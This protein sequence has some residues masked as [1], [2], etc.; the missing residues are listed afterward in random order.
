MHES[1]RGGVR[2]CQDTEKK[3][4]QLVKV[5]VD[6][7]NGQDMER[8]YVVEGHSLWSGHRKEARSV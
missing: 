6:V 2:G 7:G 3:L 5:R 8:K 4:N 1:Q